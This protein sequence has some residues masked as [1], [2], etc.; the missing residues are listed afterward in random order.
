[1]MHLSACPR[2]GGD[3]DREEEEFNTIQWACL[4][5]GARVSNEQMEAIM[6]EER[7]RAAEKQ[8]L[9]SGAVKVVAG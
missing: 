6:K 7:E 5:C 3:L 8:R 4:Q 1:M 2:C 9:A